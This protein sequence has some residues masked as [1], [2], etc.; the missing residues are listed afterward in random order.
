M[1][2]PGAINFDLGLMKVFPIS[3][4][5]KLQFRTELFNAFNTPSLNNPITTVNT[6]ARFGRI[7]SAGDPRIMQFALRISF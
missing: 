7:E 1:R 6:P 3:E 5:I 2:G 4:R